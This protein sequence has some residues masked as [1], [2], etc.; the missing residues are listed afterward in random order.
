MNKTGLKTSLA[1]MVFLFASC[2]DNSNRVENLVAV[3]TITTQKSSVEEEQNYAG[4]IEELNGTSLSFAVMGTV[5][6]LSVSEGQSVR[7]GQL[8]GTIDASN[9]RNAE[10]IAY[11][12]TQQAQEALKQ[13]KDAYLR[14]KLLHDN[15]SLPEIKWVEVETKVSQAEKVLQQTQA[16]EKIAHKGLADTRL[17]APFAGYIA[18]KNAEVGQNVIPGQKIVYLVK[19]DQVKV[20][21]SVP[22]EEIAKIQIGQSVM[23]HVSSLGKVSF[24]GKVSEKSIYADPISRS[25]TVKAIVNNPGHKLLPGMVCDVYTSVNCISAGISL[26]ANIIQVDIDNNPF[27]WTVKGG[28]AK[29]V[30]VVL[31][32]DIGDR[33]MIESGLSHGERVIVEGQQKVSN[34]M[35]VKEYGE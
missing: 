20:K 15:G 6:T 8:I 27:V 9:N 3:K 14:M 21:I 12:A 29:K 25:Y 23:F 32:D 5:K 4:T 28:K 26:P 30:Y 33:T 31:G 1:V 35:K 7:A 24:F 18:G 19:I 13:A 17:T 11:A 2:G 16:S 22:E 10:I 34:G